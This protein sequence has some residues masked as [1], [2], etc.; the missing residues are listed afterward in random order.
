M[1]LQYRVP[2][3][4]K[5]YILDSNEFSHGRSSEETF[6]FAIAE[7]SDYYRNMDDFIEGCW[8]HMPAELSLLEFQPCE[9][10]TFQSQFLNYNSLLKEGLHVEFGE[11]TGCKMVVSKTSLETA[12]FAENAD[13]Y[14]GY[15]WWTTA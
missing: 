2:L 15:S 9:P 10:Q 8:L 4:M 3:S 7:K 14:F 6:V 1:L 12:F 5:I 11:L 13:K